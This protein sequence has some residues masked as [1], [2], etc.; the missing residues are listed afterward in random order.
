MILLANSTPIVCDERTRHSFFTKRWRR[1]DLACCQR[2][3]ERARKAGNSLARP[4]GPQQYDLCQVVVHAPQL[5]LAHRARAVLAGG[6]GPPGARHARQ[7]EPAHQLSLLSNETESLGLGT[8]SWSVLYRAVASGRRTQ[9]QVTGSTSR[10]LVRLRCR[11]WCN[12][13]SLAGLVAMLVD[14]SEWM[15]L[16]PACNDRGRRSLGD[17]RCG[18]NTQP[19]ASQLRRGNFAFQTSMHRFRPVSYG[20][21]VIENRGSLLEPRHPMHFPIFGCG[22]ARHWLRAFRRHSNVF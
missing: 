8:A 13:V 12:G 7:L 19:H 22:V 3:A 16:G 18:V 4:A 14:L 11:V 6:R 2:P 9:S 5:L 1:H 10:R 17:L 21:L 15:S 20:T